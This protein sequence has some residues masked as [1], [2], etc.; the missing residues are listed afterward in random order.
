[1]YFESWHDFLQMG[2]H[3]VYVWSVYL[4]TALVVA[5]NLVSPALAQRRI[6]SR[7]KKLQKSTAQQSM[8]RKQSVQINGQSSHDILSH[9]T[10]VEL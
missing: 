9:N 1:M 8:H 7:I 5:Y 10:A 6:M 4:C 3:G 2:Q